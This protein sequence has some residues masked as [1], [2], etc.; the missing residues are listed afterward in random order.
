M[1][2]S[3]EFSNSFVL[4]FYLFALYCCY[5]LY[6]PHLC[7]AVLII[8]PWSS[9]NHILQ[10]CQL[11]SA[12][13]FCHFTAQFLQCEVSKHQ[14]NRSGAV[15]LE[16]TGSERAERRKFIWWE[17]STGLVSGLMPWLDGRLTHVHK[18]QLH[19]LIDW[20]LSKQWRRC[21]TDT[22]LGEE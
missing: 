5:S 15:K 14:L 2:C 22:L 1:F 17:G 8:M 4:Q 21:N 13:Y 10:V 9:T 3:S 12:V 16:P 11:H 6:F 19:S 20:G 18:G 7:S